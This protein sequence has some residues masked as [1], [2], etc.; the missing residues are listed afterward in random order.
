MKILITGA[1][2]F[3]GSAVCQKLKKKAKSIVGIDSLNSYYSPKLKKLRIAKTKKKLNNKF[4]FYKANIKNYKSLEKIF[5]KHKFDIVINMAAQAGVRYSIDNP[6]SYIESNIIGFYNILELSKK[7][8]VKHLVYA[9]SSSVYG[10][11]K[12]LPIK[13]NLCAYKPT[14]LY[15][16]TKLSN[17]MMAHAYSS[18]FKL[19]TTGLRFFTVYGP[20]GRPDMFLFKFVSSVLNNKK[21]P[22]YNFGKHSRDFTYIDDITNGIIKATFNKNLAKEGKNKTPFSVFNLG[23]GQSVNIL[24]FI[25]VIETHLKK[26]AK[27]VFL[28]IQKGDICKTYADISMAKKILKYNPTTNYKTGIKK[29]I[30][31]Y[32]INEKKL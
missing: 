17:E 9:S 7:Y 21:V 6:K 25:K 14:Q 15:A 16:A 18:L 4:T 24:K 27:K 20:W 32:L 1:A 31:W 28:T 3:I 22:I 30:D 8:S 23:F 13:E 11:E 10:E 29:F 2:G 5:I 12:K 26:K 19:K